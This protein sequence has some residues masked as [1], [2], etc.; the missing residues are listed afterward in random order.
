MVT[1]FP[2]MA[3]GSHTSTTDIS[4]RDSLGDPLFITYPEIRVQL[5][6]AYDEHAQHGLTVSTNYI[7]RTSGL[8]PSGTIV[9]LRFATA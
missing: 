6:H 4:R 7:I 9:K 8:Q 5:R 3:T 2:A 1:V